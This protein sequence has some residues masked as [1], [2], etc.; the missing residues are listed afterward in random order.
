M[1]VWNHP[2]RGNDLEHPVA[3]LCLVLEEDRRT[4]SGRIRSSKQFREHYFSF[5]ESRADDRI[6]S[7]LPAE[8]RG[9]IIAAWGI[10][11]PRSA[12]KDTDERVKMVV[13]DAFLAG[14]I[15]DFLFEE[16]LNP[17]LIIRWGELSEWWSFWRRG[18]ITRHAMRKALETGF[19]LGL[20]DAAWFI[21]NLRSKGG[22]LQGTDVIADG[23]SKGELATW[24]RAVYRSGDSTAGGL[25]GA[26]GWDSLASKLP[27][28]AILHV[29]DTLAERHGLVEGPRSRSEP[30]MLVTADEVE[31]TERITPVPGDEEA[32]PPSGIPALRAAATAPSASVAPRTLSERPLPVSEPPPA[33][34]RARAFTLPAIPPPMPLPPP[35][36]PPAPATPTA[37]EPYGTSTSSAPPQAP[38]LAG[39]TDDDDPEEEVPGRY[40]VV[41]SRSPGRP[42]QRPEAPA[43][44]PPGSGRS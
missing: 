4:P 24:I 39:L 38:Y 31:V 12:S 25:I 29:L 13:Q 6:F 42:S 16:G 35:T 37:V 40:S 36:P 41:S 28:D 2:L 15:D 27:D 11:G 10:R 18:P 44:V 43:S 1:P 33:P 17:A 3:K 14:D 21:E 9:P 32:T 19:G 7:H 22:T 26:L 20:F 8:V 34:T 23:L 5:D 30:P